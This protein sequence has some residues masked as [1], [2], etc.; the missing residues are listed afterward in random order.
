MILLGKIHDSM[1]FINGLSRVLPARANENSR[2]AIRGVLLE[3]GDDGAH[4]VTTDGRRLHVYVLDFELISGS[5]LFRRTLSQ[6]NIFTLLQELQ[7]IP[8]PIN[9]VED[10]GDLVFANSPIYRMTIKENKQKFPEWR[11]VVTEP[12]MSWTFVRKEMLTVVNAIVMAANT[13]HHTK[14]DDDEGGGEY[15]T[16][17]H[18]LLHFKDDSVSVSISNHKDSETWPENISDEGMKEITMPAAILVPKTEIKIAFN[19]FYLRDALAACETRLVTAQFQDSKKAAMIHEEN[20]E[21]LK[22][23]CLVMPVNRDYQ[24][25]Y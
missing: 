16:Y 10:S 2:Y 7:R 4:L 24:Y 19:G 12:I 1:D 15:H 5:G 21:R 9:V 17:P 13:T 11:T 25:D 20:K 18:I 22:V 14:E 3:I 23:K 6:E 8:K